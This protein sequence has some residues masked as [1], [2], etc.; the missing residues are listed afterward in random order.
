MLT[1]R[2]RHVVKYAE[3]CEQSAKLEQHAHASAHGVELG[4]VHGANFLALKSQ[5]ARLGTVLATDQAQH[6]G[7]A[8]ARCAHQ[9]RD[10][11][12]RH[13]QADAI[14]NHPLAIA[15]AHVT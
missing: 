5:T 8:A 3:V 10:L 14:Q 6:R 11:A 9:G 1:Q 7:F 4:L 12:A 13:R 15:K 2:K